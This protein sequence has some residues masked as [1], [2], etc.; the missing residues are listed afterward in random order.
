VKINE[1]I[2][3]LRLEKKADVDFNDLQAIWQCKQRWKEYYLLWGHAYA[4]KLAYRKCHDDPSILTFS[5]RLCG[6]SNPSYQLTPVFSME[7]KT[8]FGYGSVSYFY[9]LLKYKNVDITPFSEWIQYEYAK[10]YEIVR[11]SQKYR[12]VHPEWLRAMEYARD[13]CNLSRRDETAF[14]AKYI[15]NECEEMVSGL[16]LVMSNDRFRFIND[17]RE[18]YYIDKKGH[19][20]TEF[21]GEKVSGALDF[22]GKIME[23]SHIASVQGFI[24]RIKDCN[25]KLQPLLV[26]ETAILAEKI[27]LSAKDLAEYQP[28][29]EKY[30]SEN[31]QYADKKEKLKRELIAANKMTWQHINNDLLNSRFKEEFPDYEEFREEYDKV[32]LN[33]LR[34]NDNHNNLVKV[35]GKIS[36]HNTK[37]INFFRN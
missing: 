34:M 11:Y 6:W 7:I 20:L 18:T 37:I 5:H 26:R 24:D 28:K 12:L 35:I 17:M 31:R 15:I 25:R 2:D 21:R 13:A 14:V 4:I 9:T 22:I 3:R 36:A 23:F 32:S 27:D 1:T 29:Y 19:V 33:W 16:N 8:N 30:D 10:F